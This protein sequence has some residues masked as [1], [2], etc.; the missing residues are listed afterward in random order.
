MA[1]GSR[2]ELNEIAT[3]AN[4]RD[5]TRGFVERLPLL[6]SQDEILIRRGG[7]DLKIYEEIL[8]DDQVKA[9]FE[10]RRSAVIK[11]EWDVEPAS[12]SPIDKTAAG[13]IKGQLQGCWDRLTDKM[14]YGVFYGFSVCE[15]VYAVDGDKIVLDSARQK[16]RVRNRRRFRFAP[17][18][19]LRLLTMAN[20]LGEECPPRKF[21]RL[22][23]GADNDDEPY[24]RGLGHWLYWPVKFKRSGIRFWMIFL[25]KYGMPTAK[26]VYRPGASQQEIDKLLEALAAMQTDAAIAVPEGVQVD[27]VQAVRAA[28]ADYGE[29]C[30]YMDDA[31]AKIILGQ[32]ASTQGTAGKLGND[33]LQANVR[34]DLVKADADLVCESFNEGPGAW[35]SEWNFPGAGVPR[36]YRKLEPPEDLGQRAD[37][38]QKLAVVGYRPALKDVQET[39][40][41]EWEEFQQASATQPVAGA[42]GGP[43]LS[44]AQPSSPA[45]TPFTGQLND[46]A[47]T[48]MDGLMEPVK[49]TV[50][51]ATSLEDLRARLRDL[52]PKMKPEEFANLMARAM[53]AAELAGRFSVLEGS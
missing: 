48:V 5:I 27:L 17:D 35:L 33:Q 4:G 25:D 20:P 51:Q 43:A 53:A 7:G 1:L 18:G 36:V 6:T 16:G 50:M 47:A 2:V 40:G 44:E 22:C 19:S 8:R 24:G 31:I 45:D 21:W 42:A 26:G 52:S 49:K 11:A 15:M 30:K 37:E 38:I 12:D 39:F 23:C 41:G 13:F 14:L 29:M 10:Q 32:T 9:A 46:A 34:L 28:G 3:L